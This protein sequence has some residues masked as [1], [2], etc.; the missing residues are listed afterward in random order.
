MHRFS[1]LVLLLACTAA[2][3][4]APRPPSVMG[5]SWLVGDLS[6]NQLLAAEKADERLEPASLTKLMA[7]YLVFATLPDRK[8]SPGQQMRVYARAW[9]APASRISIPPA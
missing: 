6:S 3:A 8:L 5:K 7:A 2:Q 9:G 4:A 1:L